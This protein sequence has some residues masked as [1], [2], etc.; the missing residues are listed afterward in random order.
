MI[1]KMPKIDKNKFK[2]S[3]CNS[4]SLYQPLEIDNNNP[5]FKLVTSY[6]EITYLTENKKKDIFKFLF[7]NKDNNHNILYESENNI[8]FDSDLIK[9]NLSD[10]FYLN[11]LLNYDT[12]IVDYEYSKKVIETI[13]KQLE[14]E[15]ENEIK[16][17]ITSNLIHSLILNYKQLEEYDE[18]NDE[19]ELDEIEKDIKTKIKDYINKLNEFNLAIEENKVDNIYL[20]IIKT[21]IKEGNLSNYEYSTKIMDQMDIKNIDITKNMYDGLSQVLNNKE[22]YTNKYAIS[23]INDLLDENKIYFYFILFKYIL[24]CPIYIYHI[25]FLLESKKNI[26]K[27]IKTNSIQFKGIKDI[28]DKFEYI[29]DFFTDSIYYKKKYINFIIS[30]EEQNEVN[31]PIKNNNVSVSSQVS[32]STYTKTNQKKSIT[33]SSDNEDDYFCIKFEKLI[34]KFD[35]KYNQVKFIK[36]LSNGSFIIGAPNDNLY[37]YDKNFDFQ[38]K[39]YF[40]IPDEINEVLVTD[41]KTNQISSIKFRNIQNINETN[42]SIKAIRKDNIEIY[43][44]SL[45]GFTNYSI[46]FRYNNNNKLKPEKKIENPFCG[47][48]EN[49]KYFILYGEKGISLY[50]KNYNLIE[51]NNDDKA[52]KKYNYK[53]GI[54]LNNNIIALTSNKVLPNGEDIIIFY[55]I[56]KRN[57]IFDCQNYSFVNGLNGLTL[58]DFGEN[59]KI[60]LCACKKY[61]DNQRNGILLIKPENIKSKEIS[62]RFFDTKEFEVNCF[63]HIKQIK[64]NDNYKNNFFFAGGFDTEKRQGVIK[65]YKYDLKN[66]KEMDIEF[67]EDIFFENGDEEGFEGTINCIVQSKRNGKILV[68]CWDHKIYAYSKPNIDYYLDI[69]NDF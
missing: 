9:N 61:I 35:K 69:E 34:K 17:L 51:D 16:K 39:I 65:L 4:I 7:F 37:I 55:D 3:L 8:T 10:H 28:V 18:T 40:E 64:S 29:I 19:N 45:Y 30:N 22:N 54:Q 13:Y 59:K 1:S 68:S 11:S 49:N 52:Y 48:F 43:D 60:L 15:K 23:N 5:I 2:I 53:G 31:K 58:I 46:D 27:S 67:L 26:L 38:K 20:D 56:Q 44:C 42:D 24:K 36:E 21:L 47:Y 57:K 14:D 33:I 66:E 6:D 41:T 63:C 62:S 50:N 25:P 12:N 32:G